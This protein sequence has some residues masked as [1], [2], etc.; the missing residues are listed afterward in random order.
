MTG[1]RI[2]S[3]AFAKVYPLYVAKVEKK[4]RTSAELDEVIAW[5]T[6]YDGTGLAEA[7][8]DER[9]FTAF[10]AQAP[11]LNP[12]R[13]LVSGTVCGVRVEAV[14]D[15]LMKEIRI[16]DKLVDELAKGRPMEKVL[17]RG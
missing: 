9:D 2:F 8:A 16:L 3:M 7:L 6:G 13:N 10:F 15:P 11:A 12:A 4:G 1:H 17:R 14:E 5:H